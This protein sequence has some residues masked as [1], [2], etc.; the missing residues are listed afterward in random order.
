MSFEAIGALVGVFGVLSA[1]AGLLIKIGRAK[2]RLVDLTRRVERLEADDDAE[3]F[4]RMSPR[5]R[6]RDE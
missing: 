5:T 3:D 4:A 6:G 1:L 2:E